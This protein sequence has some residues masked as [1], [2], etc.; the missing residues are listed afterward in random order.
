MNVKK[1]N[2]PLFISLIAFCIIIAGYT[3]YSYL[4]RCSENGLSKLEAE[5][6]A[7]K[8]IPIHF[9]G[10]FIL[11][12]QSFDEEKEE[13][14]IHYEQKTGDCKVDCIVDRCGAFD[15]TGIA[16]GCESRP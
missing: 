11:T 9:A 10:D 8:F 16:G 4:T 2:H 7:N 15:V 12:S 14:S 3:A 1:I 5:K 6:V 13:W